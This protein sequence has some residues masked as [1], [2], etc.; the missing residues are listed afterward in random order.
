MGLKLKLKIGDFDFYCSSG[1]L[2][3]IFIFELCDLYSFL[4]ILQR[5]KRENIFTFLSRIESILS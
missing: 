5:T 1:L 2:D 3:P 4:E